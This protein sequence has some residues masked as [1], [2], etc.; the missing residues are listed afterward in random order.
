M[1][2]VI[3]EET[4]FQIRPVAPDL[5]CPTNKEMDLTF[6][7]AALSV[8]GTVTALQGLIPETVTVT[9]QGT[10]AL[11]MGPRGRSLRREST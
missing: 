3:D 2:I 5:T 4:E 11:L 10:Q 6:W 1:F 7:K 9:S 8:A